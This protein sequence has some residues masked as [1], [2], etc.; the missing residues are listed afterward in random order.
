MTP[1]FASIRSPGYFRSPGPENVTDKGSLYQRIWSYP[2]W[3]ASI[4]APPGNLL[5]W[6][7]WEGLL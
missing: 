7:N 2:G 4:S 1:L 3:R 5:R 6:L